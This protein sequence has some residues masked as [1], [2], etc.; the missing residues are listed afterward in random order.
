MTASPPVTRNTP[1]WLTITLVTFGVLLTAVGLVYL[2]N[3][4]DALPSFFPGHQPGSAHKHAKHGI[5]ALILA[6]GT[7][8]A[9]WIGSGRKASR[10]TADDEGTST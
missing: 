5:A 1:V 7:F 3:T 10:S 4:A 9:A 2:I 6:A 8:A